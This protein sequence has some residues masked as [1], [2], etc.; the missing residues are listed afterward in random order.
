MKQVRRDVRRLGWV[1]IVAAACATNTAQEGDATTD[2]LRAAVSPTEAV[3]VTRYTL[4]HAQEYAA[5]PDQVWSALLA[6]QED[7][8]MPLEKADT[9]GGV[10]V[11]YVRA[12][13]PRIARK[14]IWTW[15]DCGRGPGGAPRLSGYRIT[16][17]MTAA[18]GS[19]GDLT[20]VQTKLLAS[21]REIGAIGD[22]L[23]CT[24]TGQLEKRF[25]AIVAV[26]V[27]P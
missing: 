2:V 9:T 18:V 6:A 16:L 22:E 17:R 24:S 25:L 3:D 8:A 23:P 21:A 1:V 7:L 27:A 12:N 4:I 11:Y 15:V 14:P 10:A 19:A 20:R 13:T 26:R 5:T